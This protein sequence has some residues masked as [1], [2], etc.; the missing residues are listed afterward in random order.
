METAIKTS[1]RGFFGHAA[2]AY[3]AAGALATGTVI[4]ADRMVLLAA[5][6]R[7]LEA[8]MAGMDDDQ[9]VDRVWQRMAG[10]DRDMMACRAVSP[11]G[12]VASLEEAQREFGR[13]VDDG[14]DGHRLINSLIQSALDFIKA[15]PAA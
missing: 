5:E 13:Y 3:V 10:L 2:G 6:R 1:R 8:E 7:R 14:S 11:E 4:A 15:T 9:E 12:A